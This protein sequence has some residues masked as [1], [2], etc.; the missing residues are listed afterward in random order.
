MTV[1]SDAITVRE[2]IRHTS[3]VGCCPEHFEAEMHE[4]V[5]LRLQVLYSAL[6]GCGTQALRRGFRTLH[7]RKSTQKLL[8][9]QS[10]VSAGSPALQNGMLA[11]KLR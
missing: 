6:G 10:A 11:V 4:A 7:L 5:K 1:H 2:A 8:G 9:K 3:R